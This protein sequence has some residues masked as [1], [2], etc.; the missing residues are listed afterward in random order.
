[1]RRLAVAALFC[2]F[3]LLWNSASL[4]AQSSPAL[5]A[6]TQSDRQDEDRPILRRQTEAKAE[7]GTPASGA[8]PI[9]ATTVGPAVAPGLP[10]PGTGQVWALDTFVGKPE[11]VHL[12]FFPTLVDQHSASNF[13]KANLAPFI[14]KMKHTVEIRGK[15]ATVR[16]HVPSPAIYVRSAPAYNEDAAVDLTAE[17]STGNWTVVKLKVLQENRLV[18][19]LKK[20]QVS[21]KV[22]RSVAEV[23]VV[24]ET[25]A[26]TNW[27]KITPKEPLAPGEY[28]LILLPKGQGWISPRVYDFAIDPQAP[29]NTGIAVPD[30]GIAH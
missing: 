26:H 21:G 30:D 11:L 18:M 1:M 25:L 16:L 12:M 27:Q 14:V 4:R 6:A 22:S 17:P 9:P 8:M 7:V 19:T 29:R 10:L 13:A 23:E 20:P 3:A 15:S 2:A 28:G 5:P 24:K